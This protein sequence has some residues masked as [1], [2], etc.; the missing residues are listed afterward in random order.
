VT[1]LK[2]HYHVLTEGTVPQAKEKL[3]SVL[4]E[5]QLP[6]EVWGSGGS[7]SGILNVGNI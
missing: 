5:A 2:K 3:L 4:R 7:A 1:T 6:E